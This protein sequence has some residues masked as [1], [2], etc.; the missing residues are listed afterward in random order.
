MQEYKKQPLTYEEQINLLKERGLR[1][2]NEEEAKEILSNVSYYRLKAY[3]IPFRKI[4][5]NEIQNDFKKDTTLDMVFRLYKFDRKLRILI[6]DAIERIEI[7]VRTQII[8]Q[9][10]EIH[11][12]HWQD[13]E[14][15]FNPPFTKT[16]NNGERKTFD[17]HK[18]IQNHIK[19]QLEDNKAE[20]FV[21][22]YKSKY[23]IPKNPPS[24]MVVETFTFGFLSRIYQNLKENN[25][26]QSIANYFKLPQKVFSSW[27][28]ALHFVRNICAHHSRLWNKD[29][30]ITPMQFKNKKNRGLIWISNTNNENKEENV[31]IYYILCILNYLL[32]TVSPTYS[33]KTYVKQL[34]TEYNDVIYLKSMGFPDNWENEKMWQI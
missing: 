10:C 7:A 2:S 25:D 6:F 12:S 18:E 9:L 13:K 27:L 32:Q 20:I 3:M 4:Q 34:L 5:N 28:H 15:I 24:W 14:S 21:K 8:N 19:E 16:L 33:F 17:I 31:R 29:L 22:H 26:K 1:F 23:D 30:D 11:N